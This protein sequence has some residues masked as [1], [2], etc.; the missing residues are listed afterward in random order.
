MTATSTEKLPRYSRTSRKLQLLRANATHSDIHSNARN[1]IT[2]RCFT[3]LRRVCQLAGRFL[4]SCTIIDPS[5]RPVVHLTLRVSLRLPV[6]I[7]YISFSPAHRNRPRMT[8]KCCANRR[9][10]PT[11]HNEP[12]A[13]ISP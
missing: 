3:R 4:A 6:S 11:D 10:N 13:S 12:T 9:H 8:P 1:G 2:Q 7:S 5:L